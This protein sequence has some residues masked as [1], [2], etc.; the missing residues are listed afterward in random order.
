VSQSGQLGLRESLG[1]QLS[2]QLGA[3]SRARTSSED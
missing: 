1:R 3:A 2:L